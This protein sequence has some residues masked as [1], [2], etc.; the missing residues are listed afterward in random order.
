MQQVYRLFSAVFV[1][2]LFFGSGVVRGDSN[3]PRWRG[4]QQNGHTTETALPVKWSAE[5]VVWKMQL[6]GIGQSS[7]IIWGDRIFL[8]AYLDKG[9][10]RLRFFVDR[11]TG[12]MLWQQT[13]WKGAPEKSHVLNGW[14]SASC[15]TDGEIVVAF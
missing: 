14:A 12:A 10:E 7:P 13:A 5:N 11:K 8:T 1:V 4:P 9:K 2:A 6:P 3:W 15:V